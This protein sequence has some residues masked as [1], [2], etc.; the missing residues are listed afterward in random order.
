MALR[1]WV[2][3][4]AMPGEIKEIVL[5]A[6]RRLGIE[7]ILVANKNVATGE[8][9]LVSLVRV[10]AGPDVADAYI[11]ENAARDDFCITADVPLA[12]RLVAKGLTVIDPRGELYSGEDIGER[13][14]IRDFMADLRATGVQTGGPAPFGRRAKQKFAALVDRLLSRAVREGS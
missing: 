3:A 10:D 4:D 8:G 5:R 7:T 14:A 2:D 11:V 9:P 6:S 13:L 12:A 1:I